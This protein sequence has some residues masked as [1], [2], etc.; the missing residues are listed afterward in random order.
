[1]F[2]NVFYIFSI[3]FQVSPLFGTIY[4]GLYLLAKAMHNTRRAG[5]WFSGTNL[6]FYTRNLTFRGFNQNIQIDSQGDGQTNYVILDT[7][8]LGTDLYLCYLVDLGSNMVR[9]AGR[10]IHYPGGS[11]PSADSS[12]WFN[13]KTI[14]TGGAWSNWLHM[15][16]PRVPKLALINGIWPRLTW[17]SNLYVFTLGVDVIYVIIVFAII[18]IFII[19]AIGISLLIR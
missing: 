3:L 12:C 7:D 19:G 9:Y 14:C 17:L 6:A 8:G 2:K 15:S 13:P 18:F 10:S 11:S 1:M 16:K 5:Q 4:N